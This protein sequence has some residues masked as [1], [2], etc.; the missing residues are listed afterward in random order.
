MAETSLNLTSLDYD[1]LKEDLREFLRDTAEFGS[2]DFDQGAL[3]AILKVLAYSTWK[4]S[5]LLNMVATESFL[6]TAQKR[7]SVL[8][9][10][11]ELNYVARSH[12]SA[13]AQ[14][15]LT[16]TRGAANEYVIEKGHQFAAL[17]N[18]S[19]A[20]LFSVAETT[21]VTSK[22][23]DFTVDLD[24][25]EGSYVFDAYLMRTDER[26]IITNDRV[27]TDSITVAVY[28]NSAA[29]PT[30]Y[31]KANT[32]LGINET[33]K[34]WFLQTSENGKYEVVFG[35]G[36]L[37]YRPANGSRIVIDYRVTR[38]SD[39]NGASIFTPSFNPSPGDAEDLA[40]TTIEVAA[41]GDEAETIESIR[42]RAPR[43]FRVQERAV[44]AEDYAI[45]LTEQF[46]EIIDAFAYGG[47]EASP[48]QYGKVFV[49]V[50]LDAIDGLPDSRKLAYEDFL[51]TRCGLTIRPVVLEPERTYIG[52]TTKVYYD[53]TLTSISRRT[54]TSTVTSRILEFAETNVEGFGKGLRYSRLTTYIDDSDD[55]FLSNET[56]II[57]FKL[58]TPTIGKSYNID[59]EFDTALDHHAETTRSETAVWSGEFRW[60]G[61]VVHIIDDGEG[62]LW[63][64]KA[65]DNKLLKKIGTVNY[66]HGIIKIR[67]LVVESYEGDHIHLHV[68]SREKNVE[69]SKKSVLEFDPE[70]IT[71]TLVPVQNP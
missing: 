4:N 31:T 38:G 12:R 58:L 63:I 33:D 32:L 29:T 70:M 52:L 26:F 36:V 44:S 25:Y 6:D 45:M 42:F 47:E 67:G 68:E 24:I 66:N 57:L 64:A 41:G 37:G 61:R 56:S 40:V 7:T 19:G 54:L 34:V 62:V 21:V 10:A 17:T 49:L 28:E 60:Q 15:R 69:A 11:K 55:S 43:H 48:P 65:S 20:L 1:T 18:R 53:P 9:H 13:K 35:D 5:W 16:W 22:T 2:Y 3:A 14:V 59:L 71:V 39:G 23:D 8:S 27:D 46:P 30:T 51:K 50:L